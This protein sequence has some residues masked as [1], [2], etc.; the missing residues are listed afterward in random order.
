MTIAHNLETPKV[1][2]YTISLTVNE[3]QTMANHVYSYG[4]Q[5][6]LI[7]DPTPL[8][9]VNDT[10]EPSRG[11]AWFKMVTFNKTVILHESV[12]DPPD[13]DG[14]SP[15]AR[16][17]NSFGSPGD[18]KRKSTAQSGDC[19]WVCTWPETVL[20]IF[21]YPEQNSSWNKLGPTQMPSAASSAIPG[22]PIQTGDNPFGGEGPFDSYVSGQ[23]VPTPTS[24]LPPVDTGY[25]DLPFPPKPY[26]KVVKME[27]RRI[28]GSPMATCRQIEIIADGEPALPVKDA[29]GNDVIVYIV[30]NTPSR[31]GE[32]KMVLAN[33]GHSYSNI[34]LRRRESSSDK[35]HCGCTW[36]IT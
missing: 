30:E 12:L 2:D 24:G 19:P 25:F 20:E 27:E 3:S 17:F 10:Q 31:S 1:K 13:E 36:F 22:A 15:Q 16:S 26:P 11:P 21:I 8:E 6:P 34:P 28:I 9:L 14:S 32:A 18:L 29:D 5:P 7:L 4:E 35:S 23:D 33:R